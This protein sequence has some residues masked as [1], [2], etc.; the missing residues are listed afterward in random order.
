MFSLLRQYFLT[1]FKEILKTIKPILNQN[2]N[3]KIAECVGL[4]T[5]GAKD[6]S[7]L[8]KWGKPCGK[9]YPAFSP[10]VAFCFFCAA[11][12]RKASPA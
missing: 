2:A 6:G 1:N 8:P 3:P 9:D 12:K 4:S 5:G 7:S 10:V 11:D